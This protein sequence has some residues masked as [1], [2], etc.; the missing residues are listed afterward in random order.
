MSEVEVLDPAVDP[1][2]VLAVEHEQRLSKVWEL[3]LRGVSVN[4]TAEALRVTAKTVYADLKE[5][6]ARYREE[7]L[8]QDPIGLIASNMHWLEELERVALYESQSSK[9]KQ[10]MKVMVDGEEREVEVTV[11]DPQAKSRFFMA[12]LKAREL[13]LRLLVDTGIIPKEPEQM[14]RALQ[15]FA[16][17]EEALE[18]EER[19][20]EEILESVEKLLKYSRRM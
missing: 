12:A 16:M 3:K 7:V 18:Q 15:T 17:D 4:G 2:G 10:K 19:T 11:S 5:I 13:K 8:Q 9:R 20:E 1:E 14:F 6:G